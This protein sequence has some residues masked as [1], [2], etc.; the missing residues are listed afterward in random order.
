[1]EDH[2]PTEKLRQSSSRVIKQ[3]NRAIINALG[4]DVDHLG[5]LEVDV[6]PRHE[7][8]W[9]VGGLSPPTSVQTKKMNSCWQKEYAKEPVD[10]QFQYVGRPLLTLRHQF[11][12]PVVRT[13]ATQLEQEV[14]DVPQY[15]YD[16]R[17]V[18]YAHDYKH[19]TNIPGK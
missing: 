19:G 14:L 17:T 5:Q 16:P 11:P 10:R 4:A 15:K 7:A 3:I 9:F 13:E 1:M 6:D 18:G 8:F 12:L 2:S